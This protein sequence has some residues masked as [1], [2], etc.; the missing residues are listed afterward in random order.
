VSFRITV[1]QLRF[2]RAETLAAPEHVFEPGEFIVEIGASSER[3]SA[4]RI[5]WRSGR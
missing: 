1:E 3:L 5:V 2:F 4:A